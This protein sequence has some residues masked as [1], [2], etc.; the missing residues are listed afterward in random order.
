VADAAAIPQRLSART[1][2]DAEKFRRDGVFFR[3]GAAATLANL[4][5]FSGKTESA[6]KKSPWHGTCKGRKTYERRLI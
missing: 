6:P 4:L 3:R 5:I 2:A 1:A